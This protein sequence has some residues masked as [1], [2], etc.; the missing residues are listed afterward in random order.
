M[1]KSDFLLTSR[2]FKPFCARRNEFALN[3]PIPKPFLIRNLSKSFTVRIISTMFMRTKR[4]QRNLKSRYSS[5]SNSNN[6]I[7]FVV[8]QTNHLNISSCDLSFHAS[9]LTFILKLTYFLNEMII[10][11]GCRVML[12]TTRI[13]AINTTE[14]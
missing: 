2:L 7:L 11:D 5:R 1:R 13:L 3:V 10:F 6:F 4:S 8:S 12:S 14:R 9:V